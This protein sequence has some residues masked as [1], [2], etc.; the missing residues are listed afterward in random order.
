MSEDSQ[1]KKIKRRSKKYALT[2]K[3]RK[4]A[5]L[6]AKDVKPY[7]A[8]LQAGYTKATARSAGQRIEPRLAETGVIEDIRERNLRILKESGLGD[9]ERFGKLKDLT[10][11]TKVISAVSGKSATGTTMDFIDVPDNPV[12]LQALKEAFRLAGDYPADKLEIDDR[13]PVKVISNVADYDPLANAIDITPEK[14]D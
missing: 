7:P 11:A 2:D 13:R 5:E 12:Q 1:K 4:Y 10:E 8:A 6:R 14:V 9:I 3:E